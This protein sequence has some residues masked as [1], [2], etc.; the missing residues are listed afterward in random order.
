M[1]QRRDPPKEAFS[2]SKPLLTC[3]RTSII[4]LVKNKFNQAGDYNLALSLQEQEFSQHYDNNRKNRRTSVE[5]HNVSR[6]EQAKE[7]QTALTMHL[8][9]M[10]KM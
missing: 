2:T 9:E 6:E 5:D 7:K 8:S 4:L 1:S 3:Q 10:T